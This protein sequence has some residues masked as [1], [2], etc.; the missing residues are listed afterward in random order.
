M[1]AAETP[2]TGMEHLEK[3]ALVVGVVALVLCVAL[4]FRDSTQFFHSYLLAFVFFV[5]LPVGSAEILMI[6]YMIGGTW[7]FPLRR[8]LEAGVRTFYLMA[9]LLLP[10]L[11]RLPVLY[12]WA[13]PAKVHAD[14]LLQYK[15]FYLNVPFFV[16]RNVIYF[17][18]WLLLAYFLLKWSRR[19][20]ETGEPELTQRLQKI[21]APGLLIFGLTVTFACVDWVMSLEPSFFSTI[22]GMIFMVTEA[23]AGMSLVTVAI[24]LLARRNKFSGLV[25]PQVLGDYGNLLLTFTMLWAY[26]SFSQFLI[27]W[28]G[29][30]RDEISWYMVRAEG[31]WTAVALVLIVFH[32]AVPFLLL[33]MR[34]VKRRAASLGWL[35]AG[36]VV[37]S[38]VD[39]YWLTVPAFEPAGPEFHL[40]DLLAIVGVGGLWLWQFVSQLKGRPELPL[41]DPRLKEILQHV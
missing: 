24:I 6:H 5:G 22:Y 29:N 19:Q 35:A 40:T 23:L 30:L 21:S 7:G 12:S 33:L 13:D 8:P 9:V 32:F 10:I 41:Q 15:R 27:I 11:F 18:L 36:L 26:L 3:P 31:K 39:I 14:P 20:D 34:F 37:I 38:F 4:G 2:L 25:S 17:S 28:A 16:V 1:N